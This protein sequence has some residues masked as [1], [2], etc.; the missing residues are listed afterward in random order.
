VKKLILFDEDGVNTT[1]PHSLEWSYSLATGKLKKIINTPDGES[2]ESS[3]VY[4]K[5]KVK[6]GDLI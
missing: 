6:E 2:E 1:L 4:T 3:R 5:M